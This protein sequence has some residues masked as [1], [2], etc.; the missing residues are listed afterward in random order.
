MLTP[1]QI[2]NANHANA[3]QQVNH[4]NPSQVL[5]DLFKSVE[6]DVQAPRHSAEDDILAVPSINR[7]L[8]GMGYLQLAPEKQQTVEAASKRA[9]AYLMMGQ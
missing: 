6:Y 3:A 8:N 1:S 9:Y 5:W 2:E 7:L 4:D